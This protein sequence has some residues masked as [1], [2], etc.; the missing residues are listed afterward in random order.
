MPAL[1]V[2]ERDYGAVAEQWAALGPLA[3][4][5]GSTVKSASWRPDVEV[6][7]LGA[8]NG[9]VAKGAAAGRPRLDRAEHA[10]EAILALSAVTNGRLAVTAQTSGGKAASLIVERA[11]GMPDDQ[12][13]AW[14]ARVGAGLVPLAAADEEPILDL[15][16]IEDVPEATNEEPSSEEPSEDDG[17]PVPPG[18]KNPFDFSGWGT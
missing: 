15:P 2:V 14:T 9:L 11:S 4:S 8:R 1:T 3:E 7:Q 6:R 13:V 17:P 16:E 5:A 18:G 10:A 12:L